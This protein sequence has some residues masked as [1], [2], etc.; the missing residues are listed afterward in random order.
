MEKMKGKEVWIGVVGVIIILGAVWWSRSQRTIPTSVNTLNTEKSQVIQIDQRVENDSAVNL[1]VR[2][3]TYTID[4]TS[5]TL[6]DGVSSSAT[7]GSSAKRNTAV[8]EGPAFAD[9]NGDGKKDGLVILRD[10]TS[11]SGTF[12]Y[13]AAVLTNTTGSKVSNTILLG[14]RIRIKELAITQDVATVTII[15]RAKDETMATVPSVSKTLTFK[16]SGGVI[17]EV[18]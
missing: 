12:Y 9:L 1:D 8:L 3:M 18:K 15:D 10:T 14:D 17:A 5:I 16:V 7:Q 11:G 6:V 4:G 2:N 13:V